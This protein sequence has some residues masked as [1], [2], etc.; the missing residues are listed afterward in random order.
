MTAL[1]IIAV[2]VCPLFDQ[3]FRLPGLRH[4]RLALWGLGLLPPPT[5]VLSKNGS[6]SL[7]EQAT[8]SIVF[9]L[10]LLE[11]SGTTPTV[12]L[13]LWHFWETTA[14]KVCDLEVAVLTYHLVILTV[15]IPA[16]LTRVSKLRSVVK[17]HFILLGLDQCLRLFNPEFLFQLG[18]IFLVVD[19]KV[20][21]LIFA[22]R[23]NVVELGPAKDAVHTE[24]VCACLR[25]SSLSHPIETDAAALV[26][27]IFVLPFWFF[28]L[29]VLFQILLYLAEWRARCFWDLF[30]K[31]NRCFSRW[32][33]RCINHWWY[34]CFSHWWYRCFWKKWY[35]WLLMSLFGRLWFI[36]LSDFLN[37]FKSSSQSCLLNCCISSIHSNFRHR[38]HLFRL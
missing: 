35:T 37:F 29:L 3:S 22:E 14:V 30:W 9:L 4:L 17:L 8:P 6:F 15:V 18:G 19:F 33:Y 5:L 21:Y 11:L 7:S 2:N 31:C 28:K 10:K 23:A 34:G 32:W 1:R 13:C 38:W 26:E 12:P 27:V 25:T 24:A 16:D 20:K 36:L